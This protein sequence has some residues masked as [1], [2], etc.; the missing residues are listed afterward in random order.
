MAF[1]IF[2]SWQSDAPDKIGRR[3]IREALDD[4]VAEISQDTEVVDAP[5]VASGMEGVPG[6]PEVAKMMFDR[7]DESDIFLG[8]VTLVGNIPPLQTTKEEKRT[9]NPNVMTELGY[10]AA[11]IGWERIICVMNE[12]YGPRNHLPFD[13]RSKRHPIDFTMEESVEKAERDAQKKE[14]A[15]WLKKAIITCMDAEHEG[16]VEAISK[17]DIL[18]LLVCSAYRNSPYFRDLG[19]DDANRNALSLVIDVP[20]FR[21]AI[22]RLLDLRVLRTDARLQKYAYHWTHRGTLLLKELAVRNKIEPVQEAIQQT[23]EEEIHAEHSN[24]SENTH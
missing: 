19:Q 16:V 8:D 5:R 20:G 11:R 13:V 10:A 14:L 12:H 2:Y 15:K 4:A 22:H 23:I 24:P 3:F 18:C 7:I 9:P 6:T 21:T 17:L 1:S